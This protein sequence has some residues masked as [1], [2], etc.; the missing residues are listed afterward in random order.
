[1]HV[2]VCSCI[3]VIEKRMKFIKNTYKYLKAISAGPLGATRL[4]KTNYQFAIL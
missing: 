4:L 3:Y 2:F 1:M